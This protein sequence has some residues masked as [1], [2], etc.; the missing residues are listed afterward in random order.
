MFFHRSLGFRDCFV[1][2]I[3][4]GE[5]CLHTFA[6]TGTVL[7]DDFFRGWLLFT[8]LGGARIRSEDVTCGEF[9]G[10]L[11]SMTFSRMSTTSNPSCSWQDS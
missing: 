7:I 9:L 4:R 5:S 3:F 8:S 6:G 2:H 10:L 1:S 11:R